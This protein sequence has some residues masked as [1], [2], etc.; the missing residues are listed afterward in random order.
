MTFLVGTSI[1]TVQ[2]ARA[3]QD[4]SLLEPRYCHSPV[5]LP[6]LQ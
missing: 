6:V 3:F 1:G 2:H 4:R 5:D